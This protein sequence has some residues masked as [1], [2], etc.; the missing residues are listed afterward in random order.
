MTSSSLS[1]IALTV[2]DPHGIGPEIALKALASL[3]DHELAQITLFGPSDVLKASAIQSG[4]QSLLAR[5]D[6]VEVGTLQTL[7]I[8]GKIDPAAGRSAIESASAAIEACRLGLY[9]CVVAGPHHEAAIAQAGIEFSGYPS[10]VASVCG[11]PLGS[12]FLMLVGAG[13]KIVHVTLHESVETALDRLNAD[14]VVAAAQAGVSACLRMGDAKP[15]IGIFGINPHASEG[16]LFG[17]HD[18][19]TTFPAAQRLRL[20]GLNVSQPAG[21]DVLLSEHSS[22]PH[23]LYV[24]MFHDQGHIPIKLL[25]PHAASAFSIGANVLLTTTGH[26][27]AMDIAGSGK[28]QPDA[29]LRSLKMVLTMPS[30]NQRSTF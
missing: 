7:A 15:T 21:A 19:A 22:R 16:Q 4:H 17:P 6:F 14:L 1:R 30:A 12:V 26:G 9:D 28:A 20:A 5:V 27:C 13:L 8:P 18:L 3:D 23:G 2:G 11:M 24:A 29:L 25:A 10:L